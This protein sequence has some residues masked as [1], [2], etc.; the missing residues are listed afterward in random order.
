MT[1]GPRLGGTAATLIAVGIFAI[2]ALADVVTPLDVNPAV[3]QVVALVVAAWT[4]SERLL[5]TLAT[6][7]VITAFDGFLFG[8]DAD[9]A[10]VRI[11]LVNRAFVAAAI[12]AIA[13]AMHRWM[14]A[15]RAL[16]TSRAQLAAQNAVLEDSNLDL[17]AREEEIARQNEELQSQGEE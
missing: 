1:N 13:Y 2:V 14:I 10:H 15:A 16:E 6:L 12:I 9:Y 11:L 8:T 3:L 4:R 17:S 7:M 5:W